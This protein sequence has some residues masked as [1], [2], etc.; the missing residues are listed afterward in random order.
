MHTK[1]CVQIVFASSHLCFLLILCNLLLIGSN[2]G[3][4]KG[5][6]ELYVEWG[7][8]WLTKRETGMREFV[9]NHLSQ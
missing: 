8:L 7:V 2:S 1:E 3:K 9:G 6:K 4:F 5:I